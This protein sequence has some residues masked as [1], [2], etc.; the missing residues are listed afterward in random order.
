[1]NDLDA[2]GL[3]CPA[4]DA[5]A[6]TCLVAVFAVAAPVSGALVVA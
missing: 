1:M 4:A 3:D 2:E 6:V 5:A